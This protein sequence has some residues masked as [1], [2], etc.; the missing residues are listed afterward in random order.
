MSSRLIPP[1]T[2]DTCS[3]VR[4]ISSGSLVSRQ[5]GNAVMPANSA[6]MSAFPSMTGSAPQGPMSPRP[7]TAVPSLTTATEFW[8]MVSFQA[9]SLSSASARQM[10]ATPGVYTSDRSSRVRTCTRPFVSILPPR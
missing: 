10:R 3:T 9:F 8:R 4:T 6:K 5:S 1:K 2:G 7:S